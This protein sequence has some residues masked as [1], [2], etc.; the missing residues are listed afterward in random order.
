[1]YFK[2]PTLDPEL[3]SELTEA[4]N[5]RQ[6][7]M[8]DA[9]HHSRIPMPWLEWM[10]R[11]GQAPAGAG[12]ARSFVRGY[13]EFLDLESETF[14]STLPAKTELKNA[15][16]PVTANVVRAPD[17]FRE[18]QFQAPKAV[19]ALLIFGVLAFLGSLLVL[20]LRENSK[21]TAKPAVNQ[22]VVAK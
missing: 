10:E 18:Q 5:R 3:R 7:S 16:V 19:Y 9:H 1:M 11:G 4:R 12:Y 8:G 15:P 13:C 17:S 2:V 21:A 20:Q 14:V 22:S 6:L